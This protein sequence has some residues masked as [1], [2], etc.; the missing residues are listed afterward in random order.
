MDT[1]ITTAGTPADWRGEQLQAPRLPAARALHT[2]LVAA[3]QGALI[4]T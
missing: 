3:L 2:E 4:V 1:T